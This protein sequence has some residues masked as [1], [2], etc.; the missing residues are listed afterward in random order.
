MKS[1]IN[2][3]KGENTNLMYNNVAFAIISTGP[4]ARTCKAEVCLES[5]YKISKYQGKAFLLTDSP[6]CYDPA[7]I[8]E[9]TGTDQ[10][11]IVPI[12]RFSDK[13]DYPLTVQWEKWKGIKYPTVRIITPT[14][15]F[16]SKSVKAKLFDLIPDEDIDV[17]I[18]IDA[19]VIF[20]REKGLTDLLELASKDWNEEQ[21]RIRVTKWDNE[22]HL[23][24]GNCFIHGGFFIVHR[25]YSKRALAQWGN[26][27]SVKRYWIEDVTDKDKFLRAWRQAESEPGPNYMKVVPLPN[28]F[29]VILNPGTSDGLIGHITNGRIKKHGKKAIE[30]FL[31]EFHLKAYPKGYY[32]LPGLPRWLDDLLFLGY[33]PTRGS[34]KIEHVWKRIRNFFGYE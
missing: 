28:N 27:M 21:I 9:L 1:T 33:P 32:T 24:N 16:K 17:L 3:E 20:M 25:E 11:K 23:F 26:M 13:L 10:V 12:E 18:Y 31:T 7:H 5:M 15:R 19:D 8:Q 29:E 4:F 22:E 2:P 6:E 30:D 14:K 34:Y